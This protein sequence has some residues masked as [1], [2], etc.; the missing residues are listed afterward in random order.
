MKATARAAGLLVLGTTLV[1]TPEARAGAHTWDV[2]EVFSNADG[3]VQFVEI[4]ETNGGNTEIGIGGHMMISNPSGKTYTIQT[5][6][7]PTT[8]LKFFLI[9]TP[10]FAALPGAPTPDEIVPAGSLLLAQATDSSMAY[11]P[12]DTATWTAGTLPLDGIHSLTRTAVGSAMV[13]AVN[14]PTN[15]A[16]AT[17]SVDASGSG[18]LPGIPDGTTGQPLRVSK[19]AADGST[20]SVSWD[21][22]TCTGGVDNQILYGQRS[23]FPAVSGGTYTLQGGTCNIGTASPYTWTGTP[24]PTDGS[25]LI[26]FLVVSENNANKEGSWGKYDATHERSGPG[27]NGA[28]NVCG[29]TDRSVSNTCG[30]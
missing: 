15:Y 16:G 24:T 30:H 28:S 27:T 19:V 18:S 14:S 3:S 29:I 21:T 6:L 13:S 1:A 20:L 12:F 4:H 10:G 25:G 2:W 22:T 11:S 17:G 26:W 8:G 23:G 7:P 9:A 5:T